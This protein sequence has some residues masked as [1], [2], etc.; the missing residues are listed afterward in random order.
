MER[1][2]RAADRAA[3]QLGRARTLRFDLALPAPPSWTKDGAHCE[4]SGPSGQT[5]EPRLLEHRLLELTN[6]SES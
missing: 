4:A 6:N 2:A 5:A 3:G 1:A